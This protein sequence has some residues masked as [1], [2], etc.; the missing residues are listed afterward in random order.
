MSATATV[1]SLEQLYV[2]ARDEEPDDQ[3]QDRL[4]SALNGDPTSP[5]AL[6][7]IEWITDDDAKNNFIPTYDDPPVDAFIYPK[8]RFDADVTAVPT[9]Q[10]DG[11]QKRPSAGLI[12]A[13]ETYIDGLR[14]PDVDFDAV[15]FTEQSQTMTV[16]LDTDTGYGRDWGTTTTSTLTIDTGPTHTRNRAYLTT[17]PSTEN[18]DIGHHVLIFIGA[19]YFPNVRQVSGVSN[20]TG[21]FYIDVADPF[22]DEDDNETAPTAARKIYNAGPVSEA[23]VNKLVDIFAKL[24]PSDTAAAIRVPPESQDK[25]IDLTAAMM[26]K[27]IL[28]ATQRVYNVTIGVGPVAATAASLI[29]GVLVAFIISPSRADGW[30]RV[31]FNNLN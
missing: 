29:G 25:P 21:D 14:P 22:V 9:L 26:H 30:V 24:T 12:T 17:A 11:I 19:N 3:M 23:V 27:A 18:L 4:T 28:D 31:W 13:T 5:S 16:T 7:Y 6:Q 10:W 2:L 8:A 15:R 1:Y 20:A